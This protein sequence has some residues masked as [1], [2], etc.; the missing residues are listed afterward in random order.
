M[1]NLIALFVTLAV[2]ATMGLPAVSAETVPDTELSKRIERIEK[3]LEAKTNPSPPGWFNRIAVSGAIEVEAGYAGWNP[4]QG[5][6]TDESDISV[7]TVELGIEV[8]FFDHV[9]GNILILY[10]D[11]EDIVVDEA[12]ITISG[13]DAA[14]VYLSAGE[15]YVP[16]GNFESHMLSDPLTLEI[17]E[18][19]ETAIRAGF[20]RAGFY[21]SGFLFNGDVDETDAGDNTIDNFGAHAGYAMDSDAFSLDVGLSYINNLIDADGWEDVMDD[22]ALAL[23]EYVPGIAAHAILTV[24]PVTLIGEYA[25]ALEDIKWVDPF[26][27][28][29]AEKEISAWN[30]EIGFAFALLEKETVAAVAIQGTDAAQNRFP[31]SRYLISWGMGIFENT[32]LTFEYRNDEYENNDEE[33]A[34][35][36][37]VAYEF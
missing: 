23:E 8:G 6:D 13:G 10:E 31:E 30:V 17:A 21:A 9:S 28:S 24:G 5:D 14:P 25:T 29:I 34:F 15:M 35:T 26:G 20:E 19:R 27:N 7:A 3:Q 16:F 37:Q 22:E 11:G 33:N 36:A 12:F 18:T 2:T 32:S 4:D 1:K